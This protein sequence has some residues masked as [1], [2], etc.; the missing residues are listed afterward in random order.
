MVEEGLG[1]SD[2]KSATLLVVY[3]LMR[4]DVAECASV[5]EIVRL[6]GPNTSSILTVRAINSLSDSEHVYPG[7]MSSGEIV[8]FLTD[9]GIASAENFQERKSDLA[10]GVRTAVS[11]R[12]QDRSDQEIPASDRYV[13]ID[14]NK[15]RKEMQEIAADLAAK[16][17]IDNQLGEIVPD[18]EDRLILSDQVSSLSHWL[19]RSKI[20]R[21]AVRPIFNALSW[22]SKTLADG[23]LKQAAVKLVAWLA[24][25][26]FS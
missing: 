14:D 11:V 2:L 15:E 17:P 7:E 16:F 18:K 25:K 5:E 8:Y 23:A 19:E 3:E 4:R 6:L 21:E 12:L 20:D 10:A 26:I 9:K 22:V 1:F 24:G 13:T